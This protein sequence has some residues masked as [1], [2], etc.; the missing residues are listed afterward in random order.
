MPEFI[1][2]KDDQDPIVSD[3]DTDVLVESHVKHVNAPLRAKSLLSPR[4]C[5]LKSSVLN[6]G[7]LNVHGSCEVFGPAYV[8]GGY[9]AGDL[10]CH[11]GLTLLGDLYVGG[12]LRVTGAELI[13]DHKVIVKGK[14]RFDHRPS[15]SGVLYC[16]DPGPCGPD[17]SS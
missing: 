2:S 8:G 12:D 7:R 16:D 6:V 10:I 11:R 4:G 5:T 15:G 1:I 3:S 17:E 9:C 13:T 14:A